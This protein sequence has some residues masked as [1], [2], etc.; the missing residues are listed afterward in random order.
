ML[1]TPLPPSQE[2]SLI[3]QATI[4][5]IH[6]T[7]ALSGL[8]T[9]KKHIVDTLMSPKKRPSPAEATILA[10]KHAFDFIQHEW[11][12]SLKPITVGSIEEVALLLFPQDRTKV[13]RELKNNDRSLQ[14]ALSYLE[15][16]PDH[17]VLMAATLHY[18]LVA[19]PTIT[20]GGGKLGRAMC[21]LVL[22]KYG[23]HMRNMIAPEAVLAESPQTYK[24]ELEIA[25]REATITSWLEYFSTILITAMERLSNEIKKRPLARVFSLSDRQEKI[26]SLLEHP[27]AKVTNRALQRRFRISQI[28]ASR[29]LTKLASLGLL[30]PHGKG[31]SIYYTRV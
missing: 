29:D 31:R 3:W 17:P 16:K 4:D 28:T 30:Y 10:T 22:A 9:T 26:L 7:L 27:N 25:L 19:N 23:Y 15:V 11:T 18:A 13:F 21:S 14:Q 20:W 1:L 2:L 6:G 5:R 12:G 8:A 24:R